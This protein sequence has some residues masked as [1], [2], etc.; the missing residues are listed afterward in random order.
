VAVVFAVAV[1]LVHKYKY[2]LVRA[3]LHLVRSPVRLSHQGA[4]CHGGALWG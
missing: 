4:K 3:K 1:V 2:L